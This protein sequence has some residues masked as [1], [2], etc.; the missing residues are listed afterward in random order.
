MRPLD[1][2][3]NPGL[4]P[5]RVAH[6]RTAG[7]HTV[8]VRGPLLSVRAGPLDDAG[9]V[10]ANGDVAGQAAIA[11]DHVVVALEAAGC[12]LADVVSTTAYVASPYQSDI[13]AVGQAIQ[14]RLGDHGAPSTLLGVT[15]LGGP[16]QLVEIE[17]IAVAP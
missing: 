3:W 14:E 2:V 13:A 15:Q 9:E 8:V 17:A 1:L 10:L 6:V 5:A 11:L 12:E 16:G 4:Q 7:A